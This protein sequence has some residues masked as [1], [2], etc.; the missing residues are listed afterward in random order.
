MSGA[1]ITIPHADTITLETASRYFQAIRRWG[2]CPGQRF[3]CRLLPNARQHRRSYPAFNAASDRAGS[4]SY[5]NSRNR[6]PFLE[7]RIRFRR[8]LARIAPARPGIPLAQGFM[9]GHLPP[10]SHASGKAR[11]PNSWRHAPGALILPLRRQ[12]ADQYRAEPVGLRT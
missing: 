12:N 11:V 7:R 2:Y 4:R 10:D 3:H 9:P 6:L 8:H 5:R 1:A